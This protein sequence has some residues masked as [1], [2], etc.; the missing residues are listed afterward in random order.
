[1]TLTNPSLTPTGRLENISDRVTN[2]RERLDGLR[3][4]EHLSGC[5]RDDLAAVRTL[6]DRIDRAVAEALGRVHSLN[7][8]GDEMCLEAKQLA[9]TLVLAEDPW[10]NYAQARLDAA[11]IAHSALRRTRC[12][13][14]ADTRQR[15]AR[16]PAARTC[17]R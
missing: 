13:R 3:N 1:M 14:P 2:L 7:R 12:R 16:Q 5:L 11:T 9:T 15:A 4:G 10:I 6:L 8:F 17:T